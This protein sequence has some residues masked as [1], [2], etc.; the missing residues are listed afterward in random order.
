MPSKA[1]A[2]WLRGDI[3]DITSIP[4]GLLVKLDTGVPT[5]CS[6]VANG[7]MLIAEENRTMLATALSFYISGGRTADIYVSPLS[8]GRC[9]VTQFD[10]R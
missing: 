10:P 8:N 9:P 5:N 4:E 6:G 7:W 3:V 2:H 1:A